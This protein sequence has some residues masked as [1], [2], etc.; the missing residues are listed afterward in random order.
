MP[1][2]CVIFPSA[3]AHGT[4]LTTE[5][6]P[7]LR[8]TNRRRLSGGCRSP[9]FFLKRAPLVSFSERAADPA[10][11]F[12][13]PPRPRPQDPTYI[14]KSD[15][16]VTPEK[17]R[18]VLDQDGVVET[19]EHESTDIYLLPPHEDPETCTSWLRMR[20][21]DGHYTLMFEETVCDGDV[22]ISPRI[23]FEVGVRILGGLMALG[24]EVGAIMK[25]RSREWS[26][27]LLSVKI[28]WIEGLDRSFTQIQG[29]VR[30]AVVEAASKLG[31]DGTYIPHSYI[32]QVQLE[33]MTEELRSMTAEMRDKFVNAA[34]RSMDPPGIP[35]SSSGMSDR[36]LS[37]GQRGRRAARDESVTR[38]QDAARRRRGDG[39][40]GPGSRG[41]DA[42]WLAHGDPWSVEGS[43]PGAVAVNGGR[44]RRLDGR[45]P[46]T[47]KSNGVGRHHHHR[48][49]GGGGDHSGGSGSGGEH[50]SGDEGRGYAGSF[51]A[52]SPFEASLVASGA[53]EMGGVNRLEGRLNLLS[54]RVDDLAQAYNRAQA[55]SPS[56]GE[57]NLRALMQSQARLE[58]RMEARGERDAARM[59]MAAAG[60]AAAAALVAG[61][62]FSLSSRK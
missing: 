15:T 12:P 8:T 62:V 20:N 11:F 40:R 42:D 41:G 54:Q 48:G 10:L 61:V 53:I 7:R 57:E 43:P 21:R 60:G 50:S 52:A 33:E 45:P 9:F 51:R 59:M 32:E 27:E 56:R 25:R 23:K 37:S 55:A 29:K 28:D 4:P 34:R 39:S 38:L 1:I 3:G 14:L 16:V 58:A 5:L 24:Y 31:L 6:A 46:T 17:I 47:P 35:R 18:E 13:S 30:A 2:N 19:S 44:T 36:M 49:G 22:M 26:D